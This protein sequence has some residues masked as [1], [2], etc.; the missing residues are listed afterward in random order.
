[1]KKL[2]VVGKGGS[3]K[4]LVCGAL[5]V[6]FAAMK[7]KVL[8]VGCDPKRDSTMMLVDGDPPSFLDSYGHGVADE[9]ALSACVSRGR[10]GMDCIEAGGPEPGAGCAGRGILML[11]EAFERARFLESRGYD[12]ALFDVLGDVVCGGFAA[13]LRKGFG[14]VVF[15]VVTDD[16]MSLWAAN[17]ISRAVARHAA[18]GARLGGLIANCCAGGDAHPAVRNFARAIG[19]PLVAALP[20]E[21]LVGQAGFERQTIIEHAPESPL[22]KA[23]ADTALRIQRGEVHPVVPKPLPDPDFYAG[24]RRKFLCP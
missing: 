19:A 20:Y 16:I 23:L 11:L 6:L 15:V 8:H 22:S 3:G 13:P 24:A 12:L 10:R 5:S 9:A 18:G 7:Q 17:N 14:E 21:P 4:S 1:M 2:V